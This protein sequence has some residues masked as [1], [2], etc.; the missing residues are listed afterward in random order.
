[1]V[2]DEYL[3]FARGL[4]FRAGRI[5]LQGFGKAADV[6]Y[7]QDGSPVTDI[8]IQVNKMVSESIHS[9]YP[10]HGL[11]GEELD[12]GTGFEAY[13][14]ICDPLDGTIPFILGIP[15]SMFMLALIADDDLHVAVAYDPFSGRLYHATKDG[16]A[17]CNDYPIHVS[18]QTI[19]DGYLVLDTD[20]LPFV[21]VFKQAGGRIASV[22]GTGYRAMMVACGKAVGTVKDTADFHDIAPASLIV[23]EAGGRVTDLNGSRLTLDKEIEGGVI[24]SNRL[25]HQ[26]LVDILRA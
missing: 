7:K 21:T 11:L 8:D 13:R 15:N 12:F 20:S 14:W 16:G 3:R 24:I 4:A 10:A 22:G 19:R 18:N 9:R 17:F 25:A 5:I 6:K 26:P 1:M 23:A 2:A